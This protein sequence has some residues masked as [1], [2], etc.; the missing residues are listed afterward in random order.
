MVRSSLLIL[1]RQR[2]WNIEVK[3]QHTCSTSYVLATVPQTRSI[4]RFEKRRVRTFLVEVGNVEVWIYQLNRRLIRRTLYQAEYQ[5]T[6]RPIARG[7]QCRGSS[8]LF[9]ARWTSSHRHHGC[10]CSEND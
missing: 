7:T 6:K 1:V 8:R 2:W 9:A 4:T 5:F 10:D 3:S